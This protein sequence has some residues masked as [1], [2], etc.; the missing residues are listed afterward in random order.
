M[1]FSSLSVVVL[2][3]SSLATPT[4]AGMWEDCNQTGDPNLRIRGCT[5]AILSG[6]Y[7]GKDLA[8]VYFNR[9][10]A[11][12]RFGEYRLAIEDYG[13]A[14]R[15]DPGY[16]TAYN[17]RANAYS[18]LGNGRRAIE[19]YDRALRLDPGDAIAYSNR[20]AVYRKLG[21]YRR[22]IDDYDQALR[23]DPGYSD[24]YHNR[25]IANK[26]LGRYDRAAEDWEQ[27]IRIDGASRAKWWQSYM[28]GKGHY[29]GA[30]DGILG[31]GTR[32]AL[33]ACARD[34]AC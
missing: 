21:E 15:L 22:A 14:L 1:R 33:L 27:A 28:K 32:R 12:R 20:G 31:P 17:N 3:L 13:Q 25:G 24:A 2:F 10:N 26:S 5:I 8:T 11:A 19:D 34:P 16:A 6:Q 29:A 23:I 7:S 9:A 30:L 18:E 4:R